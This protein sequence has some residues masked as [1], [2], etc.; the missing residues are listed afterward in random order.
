MR[1]WQ[2]EY[3]SNNYEGM[4][5]ADGDWSI[6]DQF[7]GRP[8][9]AEWKPLQLQVYEEAPRSDAPT[10]MGC[11]PL[12]S[13]RAVDAVKALIEGSVEVLPTDFPRE[14]YFIL[15]VQSVLDCIDYDLA[16]AVRF[17]SGRVMRFNKYAF[18]P[19][20]VEGQHI[21]KVKEIPKQAV[22]VS[23]EFRNA[24]LEN[25]LVGFVFK[26]VWKSN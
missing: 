6:A 9:L 20:V 23:D 2:L 5:V 11:A 7:I 17:R 1:F 4:M 16:E 3:D 18:I 19:N 26:E 13:A 10:F 22:F 24:I 8:L 12:F 15:N 25:Q 14:P 21:F